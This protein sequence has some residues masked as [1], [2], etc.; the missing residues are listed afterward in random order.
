MDKDRK[1]IMPSLQDMGSWTIEQFMIE[2]IY[3]TDP[4]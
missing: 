1:K 3:V 2:V 4:S